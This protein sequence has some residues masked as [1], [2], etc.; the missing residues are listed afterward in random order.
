M[1]ESDPTVF[2]SEEGR[3]KT[4][5]VNSFHKESPERIHETV[6]NTP[7]SAVANFANQF[8]FDATVDEHSCHDQHAH[9]MNFQHTFSSHES[10]HD[11]PKPGTK[12]VGTNE[13]CESDHAAKHEPCRPPEPSVPAS[14]D[15]RQPRCLQGVVTG[16]DGC[17]TR[18]FR[19]S[20]P[21]Q[22][23]SPSVGSGDPLGAMVCPHIR[24]LR[25]T[26][27]SEAHSLC[28]D[29]G[30]T[31]G[32]G[33]RNR[34]SPI[35]TAQSESQSQEHASLHSANRSRG[36]GGGGSMAPSRDGDN[37][38]LHARECQHREHSCTAASNER[39]RE[40]SGGDPESSAIPELSAERWAQGLCQAG[41]IDAEETCFHA[42][43]MSSL[44]KRM[45]QLIHQFTEELQHVASECQATPGA[46]L[47][48][49]EVFCSSNSELTRQTG[50]L[51]HRA[52]RFG[53]DQGD[54]ATIEGRRSLFQLMI[55]K[56]PDNVWISPTCGPWSSWNNLNASKSVESFDAIH[57]QRVQNLYQLA[58]GIVLLR[59]Q[60]FSRRHFHWEQPRRSLMFKSPLLRELFEKTYCALFD[61]CKVGQLRDPENNKLIQK[62]VEIRTT[63]WEVFSQLHGRYCNHDH[64]H[65]V[66]EGTTVYKGVRM[67]RTEF[68]ELYP[69]KFARSLAKVLAS[70][71]NR[72]QEPKDFSLWNEILTAVGKRPKKASGEPSA[73]RPK[74]ITAQLTEPDNLPQ[75]RRRVGDK[76]PETNMAFKLQ[77]IMDEIKKMLPRVGK[78][79]IMDQQIIKKIQNVF[80]DK[81]I[82]HVVGCKGTERTLPPP[83]EMVEGEAPYRRAIVLERKSQRIL[84]ENQWEEWEL[85]A[86]RKLVRSLIPSSV[87]ITVFACNHPSAPTSMPESVIQMPAEPQSQVPDGQM[88]ELG[89]AATVN[90]DAMAHQ[91]PAM[92]ET[93]H[94]SS[95]PP[96]TQPKPETPETLPTSTHDRNVLIDSQSQQH[97]SRF[98]SL[99][100]HEKQHLL[101]VHKNFGHPS[102]QVLSQVLRRQGYP[103]HL[104]Q[105]LEDMKCSVCVQHQHPKIQRPATIKAELDFG[106]KVSIDGV[107]WTNKTG[108]NFHFYHFLDHGTNY[109]TA[110]IAPNRTTE[111]A[112][113]KL[114]V[115][116]LTWAGPPNEMMADSATEFNCEQF[117]NFLQQLN[118]KCTI[119]PPGAHWQ[120]GRTERHGDVLQKMLSKYEEDHQINSYADLQRALM[121]CTAAKNACSLRHGFS[122][123]MLVFGKG[124]KVP[125]SLTSDESLPAHSL[126]NEENAQGIQFRAQLAMRE[127]ARKAFHDADNSAALRRAALRRERPDRGSYEPG[128]WI[129]YWKSSETSKAWHGPAKVIQQDGRHSIFCLHMGNMVRV[130]PEHV[131]PV[132]AIE[133]QQISEQVPPTQEQQSHMQRLITQANQEITI[134][135][136]EI[137]QNATRPLVNANNNLLERNQNPIINIGN[138]PEP[139]IPQNEPT[140]T[141]PLSDSSIQPDQEPEMEHPMVAPTDTEM[142]QAIETPV[143]DADDELVCDLLL[144]EDIEPQ[145]VQ[146]T[147]VPLA[148][149]V[150]FQVPQEF[151]NGHTIPVEDIIMLATNQKKSRTEV[152]L[153]E[154]TSEERAEFERAKSTEVNNWLQ[155][156]TV[157]K[158]LRDS[159]SPEQ[160]LRCRWIHVW[161]PIEDPAE[162]KRLGKKRKAKSRLVVLGYLDPE[163]E[164]IPRD[165]PTLN[166]QSRM[167]ILQTIASLQWKL[168]SFDIKAAFL[169]G[170]TQE[171]RVIGLEPVPELVKAMGLQQNEVCKLEK[172]AYGL[173]DAPYLWYKELDK[174]LRELSFRPSP[175]DP[176]VYLLYKPGASRPSGILGMHVDDGLCGGDKF[177]EEQISKLES[178]F[179]FGAKK[180][181][182][183]TFTGIE[184][185][186]LPNHN[187]ILSQEKYITK[188]E[189]IHIEPKRKAQEDLPVTEAE[190]LSLRAI[191]G[192]LQYA[193][194]NTRPDLASRLRHLQSAINSA[195]ISTLTEANK[196]LH[197]AKR[198]KDTTIKIQSIPFDQLR[199]IA[200][201]DASFSSA[202]QPD[203]HTGMMIMATHA[204]IA[205]NFQCPVSPIS[206]CC[207]KIQKVV[208]STLS[209]ETMSMNSTLDQLS[210]IRLFWGWIQN[211]QIQWKRAKETLNELPPT[212]TAPTIKDPPDLAI[213]DCKSLY[214]IIT[215]TAP[216]NCQEYRT[217][218][219]CRAMKD[220]LSEGV[221]VRWVHTGARVADALTKVMNTAFLRHTLSQ[222]TYR[223]NDE[224]EI[225]RERANSRSRVQ[226]LQQNSLEQKN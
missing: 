186:Q 23:I 9:A 184:M 68:S 100:A 21:G 29:D 103:S 102:H 142:Q 120:M 115:G 136:N 39:S 145:C 58:L 216:P 207:K 35:A 10:T 185:Q 210:W 105:A 70:F 206:W 147:E 198:H 123:E 51:G 91:E 205:K 64:E 90:P 96:E 170:K 195:K 137:R 75:K 34:T 223:L 107:S 161:K 203:S 167:L 93:N 131:R 40:C 165:S 151:E 209:A 194:V 101:R 117:A 224:Q 118:V 158:V 215:R 177:F 126:A 163:L 86:Q 67:N 82:M 192:S 162:Q 128:E 204:D 30:R 24:E 125:G 94:R 180:S 183:F 22:D 47:N 46:K 138:V 80:D 148:W 25:E 159:L 16:T 156:G 129:M 8:T 19:Q 146:R 220:L 32:T 97:G 18:Q 219:Q 92:S 149:R 50:Q 37:A 72:R 77:E 74:V 28:E 144:S 112:I 1:S 197:E 152:R 160:I 164:T 143:P 85:L 4:Q 140:N 13:Q 130:A 116:W 69:R 175:F 42:S 110:T 150:E 155:T 199:F 141:T 20:P 78:K 171:N 179:P 154:L 48:V 41:D 169:Q 54:L 218:L 2:C 11:N 217:Q 172:S 57:V 7:E 111:K 88:H 134:P 104:T 59:H 135:Q 106:D 49:L 3:N 178:K 84:V 52:Q 190:K 14:G 225:L 95:M 189:P 15:W 191:I 213:T 66:L 63:S 119:I 222:G 61:M 153:S 53:Y 83:N 211:P 27:A 208:V 33:G 133:A 124:L 166:R 182:S 6:P 168:M 43:N 173:I 108:T 36:R 44:Q 38:H 62:G 55:Q 89:P 193:A 60:W 176:C 45:N 157:C 121:M 17:H 12:K 221:S 5:H 65:Q 181:Q 73:K 71:S 201:S 196:I 114:T 127:S 98:L 122:P 139:E 187:I 200:F 87:N 212:Y 109:H 174:T 113:E 76:G 81:K 214:D 226:W 79:E 31:C 26:G 202:K 132:S 99:P 56:Q 188:I